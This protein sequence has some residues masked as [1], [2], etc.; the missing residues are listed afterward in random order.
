LPIGCIVGDAATDTDC[1]ETEILALIIEVSWLLNIAV[2][3]DTAVC[4]P[5]EG[6]TVGVSVDND[7]EVGTFAWVFE[8]D[9]LICCDESEG[10]IEFD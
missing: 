4:V 6:I 9:V 1:I 2:I 3:S 5:E 10:V 8:F 7:I